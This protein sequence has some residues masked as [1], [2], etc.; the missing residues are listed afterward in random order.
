ML[1]GL[2]QSS[3]AASAG[4]GERT[5]VIDA[6]TA[7]FE[8]SVLRASMERPVLVE[9]W[10]PWCGP[11][12]Q[13]MPLLEQQ[14]T[15]R[16]GKV[17]MA[18]INIDENPE[19]AQAFRVQ[20][21]PMVVALY[22]GQPVTAFAGLRP[23]AEIARLID[24]LVALAANRQE[25]PQEQDI[26]AL[27]KGAADRLAVGNW[28]EAQQIYSTILSELP[29]HAEA[30]A[31]LARAV[32]ASGALKQA[33]ALLEKAPTAIISTPMIAAVRTTLEL[34]KAAPADDLAELRARQQAS[35]ADPQAAYAC[36]EA[37]FARGFREEAVERM[38]GLIRTHRAWEEDKAR[39]QLLR[40]FE[41]WGPTDPATVQGRKRLSSVLFS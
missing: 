38:I 29:D 13:L 36:A 37:C 20:S 5:A 33:E 41:A 15:A 21:V 19:L 32:L 9:F 8:T 35:P 34:V 16:G 17:L 14:V 7:S 23:Q 26:S 11:C 2:P 31:G 22:Q 25:S 18:K 30:Y 28:Q 40:Y 12:K 6:T 1:I 4:A 3:K 27:L 39:K 10:A 24:Q